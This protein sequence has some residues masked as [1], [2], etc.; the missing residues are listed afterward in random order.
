VQSGIDPDKLDFNYHEDEA[1]EELEELEG[2]EKD[3]HMHF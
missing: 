1:L 2:I 3:L